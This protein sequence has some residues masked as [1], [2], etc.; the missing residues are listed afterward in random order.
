MLRELSE[1]HTATVSVAC[2]VV[3]SAGL[4][5]QVQEMLHW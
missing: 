2:Y 3:Y 5:L 1:D 4:H